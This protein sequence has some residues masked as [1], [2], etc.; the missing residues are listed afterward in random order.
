M[1]LN[2]SR[3]NAPIICHTALEALDC[4]KQFGAQLI[5][6]ESETGL[7]QL[8]IDAS[9]SGR[10]VCIEAA[11]VSPEALR[12]VVY[13]VWLRGNWDHHANFRTWVADAGFV[14]PPKDPK[15]RERSPVPQPTS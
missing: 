9:K 1:P 15:D 14:P 5:I 13:A 2:R 12:D 3:T 6:A 8:V 4:A 10:W 7:T 11:A